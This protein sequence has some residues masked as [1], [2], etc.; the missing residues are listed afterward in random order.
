MSCEALCPVGFLPAYVGDALHP[1]CSVES[2]PEPPPACG[3][4]HVAG[5]G[6]AGC[7]LIV[8]HHR[9]T[10]Q[11]EQYGP[12]AFGWRSSRGRCL[13]ERTPQ[14]E[15]RSYALFKGNAAHRWFRY[16]FQEWAFFKK[17]PT[18]FRW[19]MSPGSCHLSYPPLGGV[20]FEP[21]PLELVLYLLSYAP[22]GGR[23]SN[24][25]HPM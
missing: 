5:H 21:T 9:R 8:T 3:G 25:R 23:D 11:L 16:R 20:G 10:V 1:N 4:E 22:C 19:I 15:R 13:A 17:R 2:E 7:P 18:Y 12:D 6:H 24:P 14:D